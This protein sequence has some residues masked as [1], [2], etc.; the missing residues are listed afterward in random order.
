MPLGR[1]AVIHVHDPFGDHVR[2]AVRD[3]E[4]Q[5]APC[6]EAGRDGRGRH[7]VES[8]TLVV[9]ARD[10]E[11]RVVGRR[12]GAPEVPAPAQDP[13]LVEPG[14]NVE[15]RHEGLELVG[16]LHHALLER[17]DGVEVELGVELQPD[18]RRRRR[19]GDE[20]R[21][22]GGAFEGGPAARGRGRHVLAPLERERRVQVGHAHR[23]DVREP[24]ERVD[25]RAR[26]L[27][28][29]DPARVEAV[30][31]DDR[32]PVVGTPGEGRDPI[33]K[34][35]GVGDADVRC[36][37]VRGRVGEGGLLIDDLGEP[38]RVRG[39]EA[40]PLEALGRP[41]AV[42]ELERALDDLHAGARVERSGQ[43]VIELGEAPPRRPPRAGCPDVPNAGDG[44]QHGRAERWREAQERPDRH[45]KAGLDSDRAGPVRLARERPRREPE[46][47]HEAVAPGALAARAERDG[48]GAGRVGE[49]DRRGAGRLLRPRGCLGEAA[50]RRERESRLG[51][52]VVLGHDP[53]HVGAEAA[54]LEERGDGVGQE[55]GTTLEAAVEAPVLVEALH[56]HGHRAGE[57][58]RVPLARPLR[59]VHAREGGPPRRAAR[60]HADEGADVH[61]RASERAERLSRDL[62]D[63]GCAELDA[64]G[65]GGLGSAAG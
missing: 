33:R 37:P 20:R 46:P 52:A 36:D 56:W 18:Q 30:L 39:V 32:A 35:R 64:D 44:A 65:H 47:R 6:D 29:G 16:E 60:G 45:R 14:W 15:E 3:P 2:G 59:P 55:P 23:G 27:V 9:E 17:D 38:A 62:V 53:H 48:Y 19:C 25:P 31:R 4:G 22:D 61:P 21:L 1:D 24:H 40:D 51:R 50:R 57:A 43:G 26:A 7:A 8:V 34:Q 12:V 41:G 13:A 49:R 58:R 11:P 10:A 63:P 28:P 5:L 42:V 54:V